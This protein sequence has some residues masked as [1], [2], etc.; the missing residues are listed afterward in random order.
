MSTVISSVESAD[1]LLQV[2]ATVIIADLN[3]ERRPEHGDLH[4]AWNEGQSMHPENCKTLE[5]TGSAQCTCE[6]QGG[7]GDFVFWSIA[8]G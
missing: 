5:Q 1:V 2:I 7:A 4:R 8:C 6:Q 3:A